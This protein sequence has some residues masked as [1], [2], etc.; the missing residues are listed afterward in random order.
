MS[1]IN[2]AIKL[3]INSNDLKIAAD[4]IKKGEL[5]AFPTGKL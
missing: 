2:K 4:A 1:L 5:V 3:S